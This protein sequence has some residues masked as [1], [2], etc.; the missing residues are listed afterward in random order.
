MS[1]QVEKLLDERT[2]RRGRAVLA[3]RPDPEPAPP[4]GETPADFAAELEAQLRATPSPPPAGGAPDFAAELERQ[5][6]DFPGDRFGDTSLGAQAGLAAR[7]AF[8]PTAPVP[9]SRLASV[10]LLQDAGEQLGAMP[11]VLADAATDHGPVGTAA[12]LALSGEV[13]KRLLHAGLAAASVPFGAAADV[14]GE[15]PGGEQVAG[16]AA[17]VLGLPQAG[18]DLA[19][20]PLISKLQPGSWLR[21]WAE[22][23]KDSLGAWLTG[24]FLHEGLKQAGR[25]T[26][27]P[28]VDWG[29]RPPP[30][31]AKQGVPEPVLPPE[32]P[33]A[34]PP[35]PSPFGAA[36]EAAKASGS[37]EVA[38]ELA[39]Q[40]AQLRPVPQAP[41]PAPQ[42][43]K[44]D[45]VSHR[46]GPGGSST[47]F[48]ATPPE[49]LPEPVT[50]PAPAEVPEAP[51]G[52]GETPAARGHPRRGQGG[53]IALPPIQA[54][55]NLPRW[56]TV[57]DAVG[58]WLSAL[59][60]GWENARGYAPKLRRYVD[61]QQP[62]VDHEFHAIKLR[63]AEH[64]TAVNA[65]ERARG[66][67]PQDPTVRE[68]I[69]EH[70]KAKGEAANAAA[71]FVTEGGHDE[72]YWRRQEARSKQAALQ[73]VPPQE[74]DTY[75]TKFQ[76][77]MDE[78]YGQLQQAGLNPGR[79]SDYY[80]RMVKE[81]HEQTRTAGRQAGSG[82]SR[83]L[84]GK[85]RPQ[86]A[87]AFEGSVKEVEA[88]PW[89][90]GMVAAA[91][92]E[93]AQLRAE[94]LDRLDAQHGQTAGVLSGQ[95]PF[96]VGEHALYHDGGLGPAFA[97]RG[98]DATK[99]LEANQ[100]RAAK[101][102]KPLTDLYHVAANDLT[103]G[104]TMFSQRKLRVLPLDVVDA[105]EQ[106]ERDKH[107]GRMESYI[108]QK[109]AYPKAWT[110]KWNPQFQLR[111]AFVD[112]PS[113]ALL[114]GNVKPAD[115]PHVAARIAKYFE[116]YHR[117]LQSP[118]WE[119]ELAQAR[120]AGLMSSSSFSM[121]DDP[122]AG[123]LVSR[124]AWPVQ[125][126][127]GL[128]ERTSRHLDHL[129]EARETA[130]KHAL[131]EYYQRE[132]GASP[133]QAVKHANYVT[134]NYW[135][136]SPLTR[137]L[138]ST[139]P[140]TK[141]VL[142]AAWRLNPLGGAGLDPQTGT[143]TGRGFATGP[144]AYLGA[145]LAATHAANH[146]TAA[147]RAAAANLPP[148]QAAD[149]LLYQRPDGSWVRAPWVGVMGEGVRAFTALQQI[150]ERGALSPVGDVLG[151][152]ESRA[153]SPLTALSYLTRGRSLTG[154]PAVPY[155]LHGLGS[156]A[157][158]QERLKEG[159]FVPGGWNAQAA[160]ESLFPPARTAREL[161]PLGEHEKPLGVRLGNLVT[162]LG[163]ARATDRPA[164]ERAQS[165]DALMQAWY[166]AW[167]VRDFAEARQ[168]ADRL[169]HV[170][171]DAPQLQRF[172]DLTR[173]REQDLDRLGPAGARDLRR[174]K[175]KPY[176][177]GE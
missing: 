103:T 122:Q 11:G 47:V 30:G 79:R 34:P 140:L 21:N 19:A 8:D 77:W 2:R 109:L 12:S 141:W 177:G 169:A 84:T 123:H 26:K 38:A 97:L 137:R 136:A 36:A 9:G 90:T 125:G 58:D 147:R 48:D 86:A 40:E 68:L 146:A 106:L 41:V 53:F 73:R 171:V 85:L 138:A 49:A 176:E 129:S 119:P 108:L 27:A 46:E 16:A 54:M 94:F 51:E 172:R 142:N 17:K 91:Q 166:D 120:R 13:P 104:E 56:S 24:A 144:L 96:D 71:G 110:T 74:F 62:E 87:K 37:P 131:A 39:A 23:G 18:V 159:G 1:G 60:E 57:R 89:A 163:L 118:Y 167:K 128:L 117:L 78:V 150:H 65:A 126:Q 113:T 101:A 5:A 99:V 107:V 134:G 7:P 139:H 67:A 25:F 22:V 14:A 164:V 81:Y 155:A 4:K 35:P 102:G 20:G 76:Q 63:N 175:L 45:Q 153:P 93:R 32:P 105:L 112:D 88:D 149:L 55:Q 70:L 33:P 75:V 82:G 28:P 95:V 152:L 44:V 161:N 154:D 174:K 145:V 72:A 114:A 66:I 83:E 158:E 165:K 6:R 135:E 116:H 100:A 80:H 143:I 148:D 10:G 157:Q 43:W 29:E 156:D 170:G 3:G 31:A 121:Y 160:V 115:L 69:G 64:A 168:L 59:G 50:A 92:A 173:K 162:P 61:R 15:V 124:E 127:G 130:V 52:P 151:Y 111:Q 42:G 132:Y 98:R 133:D